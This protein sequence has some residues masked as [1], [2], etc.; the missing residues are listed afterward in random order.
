MLRLTEKEVK[1]LN[2]ALNEATPEDE[3]SN[4]AVLFV[5]SARGRGITRFDTGNTNNSSTAC[6]T[7][8]NWHAPT[9]M[10]GGSL[11]PCES[12][13]INF[14]AGLWRARR[15]VLAVA[16]GAAGLW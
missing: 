15:W 3:A 7:R 1:I 11:S 12:E 16:V 5:R 2:K 6:D 13:T 10:P 8:S 14:V 9:S 4:A